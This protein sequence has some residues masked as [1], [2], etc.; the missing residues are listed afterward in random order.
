[1]FVAILIVTDDCTVQ[2][3]SRLTY[4]V[5]GILLCS[6]GKMFLTWKLHP[7]GLSMTKV[8]CLRLNNN[9]EVA[10]TCLFYWICF[11]QQKRMDIPFIALQTL[12]SAHRLLSQMIRSNNQSLALTA[13]I[14]PALVQKSAKLK[15]WILLSLMLHKQY[16]QPRSFSYPSM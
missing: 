16:V 6:W 1:M 4:L 11:Q 5:G 2:R 15:D 7:R 3:L 10:M 9:V 13:S 8:Y 14:C 12:I